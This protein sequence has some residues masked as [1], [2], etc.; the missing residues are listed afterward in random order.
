MGVTT[1]LTFSG[2]SATI[3]LGLAIGERTHLRRRRA[4]LRHLAVHVIADSPGALQITGAN[5][6]GTLEVG[7]EHRVSLAE[8]RTTQVVTTPTLTGRF[9]GYHRRMGVS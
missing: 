6:F 9:N 5:T 8:P 3:V 4:H 7:P 1:G 2:A